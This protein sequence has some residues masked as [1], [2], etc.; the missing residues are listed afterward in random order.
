MNR[1]SM[2]NDDQRDANQ[3]P[4][5]FSSVPNQNETNPLVQRLY[6]VLF[7]NVFFVDFYAEGGGS[8][9]WKIPT[10]VWKSGSP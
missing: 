10:T 2:I 7:D 8:K 4:T 6:H 1:P 5:Q 3:N 9:G